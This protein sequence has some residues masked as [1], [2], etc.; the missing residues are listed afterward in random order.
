MKK[1]QRKAAG[2]VETISA[3]NQKKLAHYATLLNKYKGNDC[4][5]QRARLIAAL[6]VAPLT[7]Y[8]GRN[9]LDVYDP[10]SRVLELRTLGW[11]ITTQRVDQ[12]THASGVI[13]KRIGRY[14]L[15][16]GAP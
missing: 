14:V 2:G 15:T 16:G 1:T 4:D 7:T 8:E 5:T 12:R 13:H 9:F 10:A 3:A 11:K 6:K